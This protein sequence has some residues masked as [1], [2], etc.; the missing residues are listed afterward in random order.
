MLLLEQPDGVFVEGGAPDLDVRRG[1]EP[2][3]KRTRV[4]AALSSGLD[5]VRAFVPAPIAG[6]AQDRH[7]LPPLRGRLA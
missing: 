1:P 3:E 7:S 5:E 4:L 6:K 2:I